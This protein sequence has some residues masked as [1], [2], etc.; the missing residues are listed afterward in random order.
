MSLGGHNW[1]DQPYSGYTSRQSIF[2][3]LWQ[4]VKMTT[5]ILG[6]H[7]PEVQHVI[8][9]FKLRHVTAKITCVFACT[10]SANAQILWHRDSNILWILI[11]VSFELLARYLMEALDVKIPRY[12]LFGPVVSY[13]NERDVMKARQL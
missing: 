2:I 4:D 7:K 8:K 9:T 3:Q 1:F 13:E 10:R 12:C 6:E 5:A 11:I